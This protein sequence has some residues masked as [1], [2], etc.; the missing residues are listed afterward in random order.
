MSKETRKMKVTM[1][2]PSADELQAMYNFFN[3]LEF[4]YDRK[5]GF[6]DNTPDDMEGNFP[7]EWQKEAQRLYLEQSG[8]MEATEDQ[9]KHEMV[10]YA[11]S[12]YTISTGWRRVI[13]GFESLFETFCIKDID[14]LTY[15]TDHLVQLIEKSENCIVTR[16][17]KTE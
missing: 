15:D 14:T 1:A 17:P 11:F 13:G 4:L 16:T 2:A 10:K 5:Y 12:Y 9:W 7:H 6:N 8:D 3:L